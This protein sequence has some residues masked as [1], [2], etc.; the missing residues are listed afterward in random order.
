MNDLR[1][2]IHRSKRYVLR[3]LRTLKYLLI[4]LLIICII[5]ISLFFLLYGWESVEGDT[6]SNPGTNI[7]GALFFLGTAY[8]AWIHSDKKRDDAPDAFAAWLNSKTPNRDQD[9][10]SNN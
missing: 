7:L 10:D 9:P 5:S 8:F 6:F 1:L 4:A 2:E 3:L